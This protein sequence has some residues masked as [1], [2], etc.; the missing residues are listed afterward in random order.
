MLAV[1]FT[2]WWL[3]QLGKS[4]SDVEIPIEVK[5][6]GNI[7]NVRFKA[8]GVGYKLMAHRMLGSTSVEVP[9][10]ELE[11]SPAPESAWRGVIGP[12]SLLKAVAARVGDVKIESVG[13]IPEISLRGR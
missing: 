6:E 5:V 1:S 2:M 8:T 4:Y 9:F 10:D 3:T 11:V 12:E 7:F 13:F